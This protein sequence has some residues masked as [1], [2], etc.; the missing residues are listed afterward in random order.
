MV[1]NFDVEHMYTSVE[2]QMS[3]ASMHPPSDLACFGSMCT[4]YSTQRC[5]RFASGSVKNHVHNDLT[6]KTLLKWLA[7][8][9]PN[10]GVLENVSGWAMR[11]DDTT[12]ASPLEQL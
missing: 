3:E 8:F 2:E 4:P 11:E 6:A 1:A 10:A 9:Q 7:T 12:D 5:K